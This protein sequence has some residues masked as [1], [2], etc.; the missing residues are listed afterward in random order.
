M[1]DPPDRT[2][3][4]ATTPGP[5]ELLATKLHLPRPPRGF[6]ARPRLVDRLDDGLARELT[7][8]CAPA[9]F[10]KTSLLADW[11][12]RREQR[13]GWLSLDVGDNDPVRFWRHTVAAL[14]RARPGV[15][16]RVSPLLGP[17]APASFEAVTTAVVNE[18]ATED[19]DALL[20]LD[21]YHLIE[22]QSVH[23]SLQ[24]LVEHQPPG[25]HVVLATRADPPLPLARLRARG[26][27]TELRAAELMFT[28]DEATDLLR[29]AAGLELRDDE[30]APLVARTEGWA[31]GL[32]LAALSLHG[33]PDV[34]GF[35]ESFSGSHRHV[36]DYLT[37]EVLE[38]Q[39]E[40][41]RD[42]L[43]ETSVLDRLSGPLC[44]AIT[45]RA[46][47]QAMLEAI[48]GANL[49]LAALDEVR[50]WWRYHPL[51]TDLLRARL[52]QQDPERMRELH[53]NA[54]LWHEE[55][56]PVDDA[57]SHALAAGDAAWAARLIE[58]HADELLL[59]SEGA[60]LQRWLAALP[61]GS[62]DA[63]PRLLITQTRFAGLE[64]VEDLLDAAEH[65]LAHTV[66]EPYEPSAGRGVS[67]L[68][69]VPAM[70]AIGRAFVAYERGDGE[71]TMAFSSRA[72]AE[73]GEGEWWLDSLAR[74]LFGAAA[75]L[76]GR[77]AEAERAIASSIA[78]WQAADVHDQVELWSQYLGQIQCARGRLDLAVETYQQVLEAA[79]V[80][81]RRALPAASTAHVGLGA[82]AYQRGE[83]GTALP[84]LTEGLRLC[85]QFGNPD[86]LA[87]GLA[88]LAWIRRAQGDVPAALE[89]MD[90]A[91]RVSDP[92]VVDLLNTVPAQ[93]A[94][95][96][97]SQ[98]D[99]AA[100]ARWAEARGLAA[101]NQPSYPREP[102]YV[103]LARV[104]L[105]QDQPDQALKVLDRLHA[106]AVAQDR[107]GSVIEI[108]AL[109]AL[110]LAALGDEDGAV[111]TLGE[112][113]T[114]AHP[115][116][117]IRVFVDE[118]PTM[119]TL[120]GQLI[121]AR[122]GAVPGDYVGRL[123]RAFEHDGAGR[124]SDD[125][126]TAAIVPGLVT[127]L[128]DRELEVLHLLAAGKQ[129]QEIAGELH[130]ALNTVKKHA[131]H[132]FD[133]LGATNRTEATVRAREFGLLTK[134]EPR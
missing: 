29:E 77:L 42:F 113:L 117:Y 120:L 51:F 47:G 133:K 38:Q 39:P 36:L 23:A 74:A 122:Q 15:A 132:I 114:L 25:L 43:F 59:R 21:D 56:G 96:L 62:I 8:I 4:H 57:L 24:F 16:E 100:A 44:D 110:G 68:A 79:T 103:L 80:P 123:V 107:T 73:I 66:D 84:H 124:A 94:R 7:L 112:T 2:P 134:P 70:I 71:A 116:G 37:E 3:Q 92:T 111:A 27:L 64:E 78:R 35:V 85:R 12:Q 86:S 97:L 49:F 30:V 6:V 72:L 45:G 40:S 55:H 63:R 93:R 33:Q 83:F 34:A 41:V 129:N 75:W 9:G 101:D 130:M 14:D 53:R 1:A 109:R 10:G 52:Q 65:A 50:G 69:N 128:S 108:Q 60:T 87:N 61:P 81:D 104:L 125:R 20:V 88:T 82:V 19:G 11:S 18:L 76:H 118:G 106:A 121:Q 54:G 115:Q 48:E 131:T 127:A 99:I 13:L 102:A 46:D 17:P 5:D 58:R 22:A 28:V 98:G 91:G 126:P 31:A 90:E 32:Q 67:R 95:L 89:A 119:G 26:Q 105:A